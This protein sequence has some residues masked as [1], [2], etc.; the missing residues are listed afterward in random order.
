M[1]T[2]VNE[3]PDDPRPEL[4]TTPLIDVM[5]VLL[6]MLILTVPVMTHSIRL[7][8]GGDPKQRPEPPPVALIEIEFDGSI[9]WNNE[10]VPLAALPGRTQGILAKSERAEFHVRPA[11]LVRFEYVANTLAAIQLN[12]AR[13]IMFLGNERYL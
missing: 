7:D 8:M 12:G 4:N 10:P 13:R 6:T 11:R 9:Y 1:L 2:A 5:L 3:R